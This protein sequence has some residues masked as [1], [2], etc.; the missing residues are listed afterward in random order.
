MADPDAKA[1]PAPTSATE[2]YRLA[3]GVVFSIGPVRSKLLDLQNNRELELDFRQLQMLERLTLGQDVGPHREQLSALAEQGLLAAGA[4]GPD[5]VLKQRLQRLDNM[6]L[7]AYRQHLSPREQNAYELLLNVHARNKRVFKRAGQCPVLPETALRR[8]LLVGDAEVVGRKRVLCVGDDDLVSIGLAAL[9]HETW[10][11][12]IDEYL[13]AFIQRASD[14]LGLGIVAEERDLRDPL[15]EKERGTFHAF[16]TD[17]MS[18]RDCFELFLSRGLALLK[19]EGRGYCA[20]YPPVTRLFHQIAGEMNIEICDWSAGHN[21]YYSRQFTLHSYQ[22]DWVTLR[23]TADTTLACAPGD[24]SVPLN[25]YKEAGYDRE[26]SQLG[27]FDRIEEPRFAKRLYLDML[28]DAVE[29]VAPLKFLDRVYF[30]GPE[31]SV[32]HCPTA[33]GHLSLHADRAR[34]QIIL[35]VHPFSQEVEEVTRQMVMATFKS[36]AGEAVV[37]G[38]RVCWDIR[39]L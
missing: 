2:T 31:W 38:D 6:Y 14:D 12:D 19:P 11:F 29:Q 26:R 16:L 24:F 9:G 33:E 15:E 25:L 8:A 1:P 20:V 35:N 36:Q 5:P 34:Q 27:F 30:S 23:P 21:H 4:P 28:L 3:D 39:V 22:S 7:Q 32:V 17:P 37:S 10:V 13:L 18:N